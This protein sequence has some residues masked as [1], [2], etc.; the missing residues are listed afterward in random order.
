VAG[1][2]I[3]VVLAHHLAL[4]RT[5]LAALLSRERDI[6]VVAELTDVREAV[7]AAVAQL[8]PN[9]LVLDSEILGGANPLGIPAFPVGP[10]GQP[11]GAAA[12]YHLHDEVPYCGLLVLVDAANGST[13]G[14]VLRRCPSRV[15]FVA[16]EAPG[17][18]LA[19]AV[20]KLACGESFLDPSVAIAAKTNPLTP[21]EREILALAAQGA[22]VQEIAEQVCLATGTVRNH[23]SRVLT[24]TGARTRIEAIRIVQRSGWL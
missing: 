15:G 6:D 20:R 21:R 14:D 13:V 16:Q 22:P 1:L 10:A 4:L 17:A 3:R 24:K 23:L 11:P 2:V 19:E 5:A 9:V 18:R 8:C 12:L 7:P